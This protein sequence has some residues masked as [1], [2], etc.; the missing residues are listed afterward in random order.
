VQSRVLL[1]RALAALFGLFG[2]VT[3][4]FL[5]IRFVPGDPVDAMLGEQ[6]SAIDRQALRSELGLDRPLVEQYGRFWL[7]LARLDLGRSLAGHKRVARMIAARAPATAELA[8]AAMAL[9]LGLGVPI[10]AL[11]AYCRGSWLD[12]ATVGLALVGASI[13]TFWLGPTLILAFSIKLN[14][15]PVGERGGLARLALPAL[16]LALGMASALA[17]ATR[18]AALETL[19]EDYLTVARAKGAGPWR[20]LFRHALAN[21][22]SPILTVAG[23]QFGAVL[24]GVAIVEAIFDW[25]GLGDLLFQAIQKRDYPTAQG[26]VLAIAATYVIVNLAIDSLYG[27]AD[28]RSRASL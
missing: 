10:G 11:A 20:I 27:L 4:S 22:A 23:L 18:A 12:R 3:A 9:A 26:C 8:L 5:L 24:T 13:P 16:T 17:L 15:F 2:V 1:E 25:P 7:G 19:H 21:A 14:L 28:P 6:A